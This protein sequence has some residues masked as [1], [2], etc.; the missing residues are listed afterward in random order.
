MGKKLR[1]IGNR[2]V[3]ELN[4]KNALLGYEVEV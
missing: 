1:I 2:T 4:N 3:L